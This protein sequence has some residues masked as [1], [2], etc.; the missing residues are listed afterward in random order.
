MGYGREMSATELW[1]VRHGESVG[2]VAA[3]TAQAASA[4]VIEVGLRDADV[5]L[6][7]TGQV[8][9]D[10][11]GRWLGGL[12]PLMVPEAVWSSPYLRAV[13]TAEIAVRVGNLPLTIQIDERLRDR[14]LGILDLL[15][16]TGVRGPAAGRSAAAAVAR[17]VLLSSPRRGVLGRSGA[18]GAIVTG[19]PGTSRSP[20]PGASRVP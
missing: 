1:L 12:G 10:A 16:T 2:N 11:L 4:D 7:A 20:G 13:E 18:A 8:Q 15:T 17:K 19:R 3:S 9:A 5:P 14:E 6:T